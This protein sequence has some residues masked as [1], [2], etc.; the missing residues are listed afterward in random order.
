MYFLTSKCVFLLQRGAIFDSARSQKFLCLEICHKNCF[1][2]EVLKQ[3]RNMAVAPLI[4]GRR[5]RR[6]P[7][8]WKRPS[9]MGQKRTGFIKVRLKELFARW[10]HL[11]SSSSIFQELGL[12]GS[13]MAQNIHVNCDPI[14][15][16]EQAEETSSS[17]SGASTS[18]SVQTQEDVYCT[19]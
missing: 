10:H 8:R 11:E 7:R 2:R 6:R 5:R 4:R 15:R 3:Q 13:V 1:F 19:A 16:Q 17:D 18:A 9:K 12:R 14:I